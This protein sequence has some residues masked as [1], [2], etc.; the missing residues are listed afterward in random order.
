MHPS[1]CL[2]SP[3]F[4]I[5]ERAYRYLRSIVRGALSAPLSQLYLGH[6]ILLRP[7]LPPRR[8]SRWGS[9]LLLS[10]FGPILFGIAWPL[11]ILAPT[12]DAAIRVAHTAWRLSSWISMRPAWICLFGD[13]YRIQQ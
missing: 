8:A 3:L 12:S 5:T 11:A 9:Y 13:M 6:L 7:Y 10:L 2:P 1:P 4:L